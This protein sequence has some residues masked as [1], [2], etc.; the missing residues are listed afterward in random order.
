LSPVSPALS[1]VPISFHQP[2]DYQISTVA[3]PKFVSVPG[4][5]SSHSFPVVLIAVGSSRFRIHLHSIDDFHVFTESG[6]TIAAND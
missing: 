4:P 5:V 1:P 3:S 2:I 6:K